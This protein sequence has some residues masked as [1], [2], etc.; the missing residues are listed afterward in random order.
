[1]MSSTSKISSERAEAT[2]TRVTRLRQ[3]IA[4]A[5]AAGARVRREW[6]GGATG[7]GCEIAG[8]RWLFLDLSLPIDEQIEQVESALRS[9]ELTEDSVSTAASG[10][11][12]MP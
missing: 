3:R 11:D 4:T 6:L 8:V 9:W 10:P 2:D 7:G 5:R 1:M 12:Q